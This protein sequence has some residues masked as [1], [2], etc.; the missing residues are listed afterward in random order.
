M[1]KDKNIVEAHKAQLPEIVSFLK[2]LGVRTCD[3]DFNKLGSIVEEAL[4][5]GDAS[6]SEPA[7][8]RW[9]DRVIE[10]LIAPHSSVL[11]VGCGNGD[12]LVR[13]AE[14]TQATVQG[15]DI[16]QESVMRCIER[17]IPTYH[18][19][20]ESA[21][22]NFPDKAFDYAIL[23]DTLQTLSH[24]MEVLRQLLRVG[25]KS[26]ISFPNFAHWQVRLAFSL[27]GRMPMTATLPALWYNTKNIHLCSIND[28]MDWTLHDNVRILASRMLAN[29][30]VEEYREE[31]NLTAQ[32]A[33]FLVEPK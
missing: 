26:F 3:T 6:C 7:P 17:G 33:L 1:D 12:L 30:K 15:V 27:G 13:L 22:K 9:Q 2:R 23:E 10:E 5:Q 29:G 25:R 16:E 4:A 21:L 18:G 24:P 28:F 14:N 11:D 32:Q 20:L 31:H 8:E 19:D